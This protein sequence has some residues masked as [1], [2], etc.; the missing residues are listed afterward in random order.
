MKLI[1]VRHGE[2]NYAIDGLTERGA[3]EAELV[4]ERLCQ[5]DI[6][7][8]YCSPLGRAKL[9][10]KP[11]LEK[12]GM[13]AEICDWLEEFSAPVKL[14]YM[15]KEDCAWDILPE[16]IEECE[17]IYSPSEWQN[18]PHIKNSRVPERYQEVCKA[19]DGLLEKH[20]Y[21]RDGFSYKVTRSNHDTLV[22]FCHYGLTCVLLSHLM[23]CSPYSLWQHICTA[24]TGVTVINTE[25]RREGRAH[26]RASVI[27]DV[28]HL[29]AKGVE[30]SFAARFCECYQDE[31]RHD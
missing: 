20:G 25:E 18:V 5:E 23:N 24:P 1:I 14:P 28:S 11:T 27:G 10:A 16:F 30:P 7:K 21:I 17:G 13:D 19:F 2:P 31:T 3:V 8:I 6:A 15:E 26:F 4:S 22:L 12:L 9:T 29:Y